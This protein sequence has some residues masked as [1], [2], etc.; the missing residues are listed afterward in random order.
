MTE[1][2]TAGATEPT[3]TQPAATSPQR[4]LTL[5]TYCGVGDPLLLESNTDQGPERIRAAGPLGCCTKGAAFLRDND[6]TAAAAEVGYPRLT[7]PEIKIHGRWHVVSWAEALRFAAQ[8]LLKLRGRFGRRAIAY[9]GVGQA[10]IESYWI[11][12]KLFQG[13]LGTNHVGTNAELCLAASAGGHELVFGNEGSFACYEDYRT[14]DAIILYGSN[15]AINHPTV[16][17]RYVLANRQA[18]RFV[19]DPRVTET[20]RQS[21]AGA[22]EAHHLRIRSGGDI[23]LNLAVAH[24]LFA[25]GW[26]DTAYLARHVAADSLAAYRDLASQPRCSPH[27]VARRIAADDAAA[28]LLE[29]QIERLAEVW[30]RSPACA[31]RIVTTSSVGINQ[32]SGSAGVASI[33]NLHLLTGT[34]G[35]PGNG[36]VRLAGQSNASAELAMG[37]SSL[38]LPFRLSV[39]ERRNRVRIGHHW[40]IPPWMISEQPGTPVSHYAQSREIR[41]LL[42]AGCDFLRN[43]P[44]SDRVARWLQDVF[45]VTCDAYPN[46]RCREVCNVLLP[47][48]THG[49]LAG[50]YMNGERRCQLVRPLRQPPCDAWDDTTILTEFAQSLAYELIDWSNDR[51]TVLRRAREQLLQWSWV[52][53]DRRRWPP[54]NPTEAD[55]EHRALQGNL[56]LDPHPLRAAF[57]YRHDAHGQ[58]E[59]AE[60][61]E[62]LR[63]ASVGLYNE[64]RDEQG[65]ISY[66][67]L[68]AAGSACWGG[69]RRYTPDWHGP[70]DDPGA[71]FPGRYHHAT[72]RARL[73]RP[74]EEHLGATR[75]AQSWVLN[76]GR[77]VIGPG[78]EAR[79]I[80]MFNSCTKAG[81]AELTARHVIALHPQDAAHLGILAG[82]LVEIRTA[83]G[84]IVLPAQLTEDVIPGEPYVPFHPDQVLTPLNRIIT[85][86][87]LDP[88]VNQPRLK[89][90]L[91][92]LR[93]APSSPFLDLAGTLVAPCIAHRSN[94]S[95]R[96]PVNRHRGGSSDDPTDRR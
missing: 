22:Q 44:E 48:R 53:A 38:L 46:P 77:G 63:E 56:D 45:V 15:Q 59:A 32:T 88:D 25:R 9:Y 50:T 18:V 69:S 27:T 6:R 64:L 51:S 86:V 65:P 91:V 39:K 23:Q 8:N 55:V 13:Y 4:Q 67:R 89:R 26:I 11:A 78:Q 10:P 21:L 92:T 85:P 52:M 3:A 82:D 2:L 81:H 49:E 7:A 47:A 41:W 14:A 73:H 20:V 70:A 83:A 40:G 1:C 36:H 66:E 60:V 75:P 42:T 34:I 96:S 17:R 43:L 62:E 58:V 33:L 90:Q 28:P 87:K 5:C 80:A 79:N 84:A 16:F 72:S 93:R 57:D 35:T 71:I 54:A 30:G 94:P 68:V 95:C 31:L 19:I 37:F 29:T 74:D 61:W 12:K 76:T 24:R